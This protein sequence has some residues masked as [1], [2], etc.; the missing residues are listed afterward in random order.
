MGRLAG[1]VL[2]PAASVLLLRENPLEVL[3]ILRHEKSSFVPNVWVFPGGTVDAADGPPSEME[4]FERAAIREVR[5]ETGI[6]LPGGLVATARWITPEGMPKRF[7]TW[8]FLAPVPR[9]TK[10]TLQ[11]SE[12]VDFAWIE[13]SDALARKPEEFPMVFPTV[14][15]LEAIA[16]FRSRAELLQSR[17]GAKIEPVQPVLVMEGN[18]KKIRLP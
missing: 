3:M 15:N 9:D 6:E 18:R 17:L 14:K 5:E 1:T 4:S 16:T 8:F 10:V 7:D 12:A 2:I 13:P 11:E